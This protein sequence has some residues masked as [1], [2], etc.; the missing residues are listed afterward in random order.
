MLDKN[1]KRPTKMAGPAEQTGAI[2]ILILCHSSPFRQTSFVQFY[3]SFMP[4]VL[5]QTLAV[6]RYSLGYI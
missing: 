2:W 5:E 1:L 6:S 3:L 4:L